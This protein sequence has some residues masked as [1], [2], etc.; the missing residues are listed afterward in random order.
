M[1]VNMGQEITFLLVEDDDV[2]AEAICRSIR[3]K[4]LTNPIVRVKDGV[5]ALD[6]LKDEHEDIRL[7]KPYIVLVDINLP[8]MNGIEL[9]KEIRKDENLA[10]AVVFIL[11]TSKQS[12]DKIDAFKLNVAAY[13][14]K[15]NAGEDFMH[16]AHLIDTY[17]RF[18][19]LPEI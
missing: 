3:G 18:A 19:E 1:G 8:R 16:A 4:G 5:D 10:H 13:I 15:C 6:V 2:D 7:S 9:L 12:H 17:Q 14:L 11:T